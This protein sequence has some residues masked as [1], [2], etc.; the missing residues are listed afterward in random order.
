MFDPVKYIVV[1]N[2]YD[3]PI[4]ANEVIFIFPSTITHSNMANRFKSKI[5]SAGFVDLENKHCYGK[6]VSLKIKSREEDN[7]LLKTQLFD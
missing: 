1:E 5:I 7:F 2:V 3:Y 4:T 6:S